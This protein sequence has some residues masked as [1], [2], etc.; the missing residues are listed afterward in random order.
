MKQS[1]RLIILSFILLSTTFGATRIAYLRPGPMMKIPYTA[2]GPSPY[3][4]TAGFGSELHNFSPFNTASGAYFSMETNGWTFG[5]STARGADTTRLANLEVSTY[6]PPVEFGFH[7]QRRVYVR[8]NISFTVGLQDIV[9]EN[10]T[11]GLNLDPKE[12]SF[13]GIVSSQKALGQYNMNTFIG[14]G[15]GGFGAIDT[16]R[17]DTLAVQPTGT[18]AG[19]FAGAVINTPYLEK[20]GGVDIVGEFD[21]NGINVGFRIPLTSDYRLNLGFTH[22][23]KLPN[24]KERYWEGH[25]GLTIGFEITAPRGSMIRTPGSGPAPPLLQPGPINMAEMDTTLML[26]DYRVHT[27]RDSMGMMTNE[28]RNLM[29]R[30][31]A[32]EQ[33]S[34][35]LEDS[36]KAIRLNTN[37]GEQK[38][39]DALRHLSRSLRYFYTGNYRTSLQEVESALEL[40]PNLALAYARRGSIYY[41]LGDIQRATINWNLALRMDPEYD[42]VRNVLKALHENRLKSTSMIEE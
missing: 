27:L 7:L 38:M 35:F 28:M 29:T 21:G 41:K 1:I 40:N 36:L 39:N 18:N 10:K 14:F 13:F 5:F 32:M 16:V 24:W 34:K 20:W 3:L 9:F 17:T 15:T 31:S 4:F 12:L 22:I 26:A 23:E 33:H 11:S 42:D 2:I 6:R 25:A 8:N 30:L 19:V 37:V